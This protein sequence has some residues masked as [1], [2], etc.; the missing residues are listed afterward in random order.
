MSLSVGE[1]VSPVEVEETLEEHD[2]VAA[3]V[4]IGQQNDK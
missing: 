2:D 4:V 1:L 3:A